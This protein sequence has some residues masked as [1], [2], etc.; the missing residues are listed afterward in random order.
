MV[1]FRHWRHTGLTHCGLR[2]VQYFDLGN[3]CLLSCTWLAF[4]RDPV[5]W[6]AHDS[7]QTVNIEQ[8]SF[9]IFLLKC[10]KQK[11]FISFDFLHLFPLNLANSCDT[12]YF[13]IY[14]EGVFSSPPPLYFLGP[15]VSMDGPRSLPP[16]QRSAPDTGVASL[17]LLFLWSFLY[18][19]VMFELFCP[20]Q[21]FHIWLKIHQDFSFLYIFFFWCCKTF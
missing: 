13:C 21:C 5:S 4:W 3:T 2:C 14:W 15:R 18:M 16:P 9:S 11:H 6:H 20:V 7:H 8:I 12:E 17:L 19:I 10:N 1:A